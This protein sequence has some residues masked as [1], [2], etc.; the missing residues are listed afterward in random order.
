MQIRP[1]A[2][3]IGLIIYSFIALFLVYTEFGIDSTNRC[4]MDERTILLIFNCIC[5]LYSGFLRSE[6]ST[7][8][9]TEHYTH[10]G[11]FS[12]QFPIMKSDDLFCY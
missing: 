12:C 9:Y 7:A 10:I 8:L 3:T 2:F 5:S 4:P 1:T 11:T 6:I